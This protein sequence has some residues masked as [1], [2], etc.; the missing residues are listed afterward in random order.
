VAN[1]AAVAYA[2]ISHAVAFLF[3]GAV[4]LALLVRAGL[5]GEVFRDINRGLAA[6]EEPPRAV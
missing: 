4:G 5:A 3:L 1:D 6:E 2:I